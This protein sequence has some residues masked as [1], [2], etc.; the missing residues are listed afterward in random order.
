MF[1]EGHLFCLSVQKYIVVSNF[2]LDEVV[3]LISRNRPQRPPRQTAQM[4]AYHKC[5]RS[6]QPSKVSF[7]NLK[8]YHST[9]TSHDA[10]RISTVPCLCKNT[11]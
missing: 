6:T 9:L 5:W 3:W 4:Q 1:K 8:S 2:K 11:Y 7:R 10:L